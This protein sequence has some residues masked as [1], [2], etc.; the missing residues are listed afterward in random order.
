[1]AIQ[2]AAYYGTTPEE[3]AE[4][5]GGN[6]RYYLDYYLQEGL[7]EFLR[8][9]HKLNLLPETHYDGARKTLL[10]GIPAQRKEPSTEQILEGLAA[11]H[12]LAAQDA[13]VLLNCAGLAQLDAA[14]ADA[15]RARHPQTLS[16][17]LQE[18]EDEQ[19]AIEA[20]TECTQKNQN[21][22]LY[23]SLRSSSGQL[24]PIYRYEKLIAALRGK[25]SA[26]LQAFSI[27]A[28]IQLAD[29]HGMSFEDA[30]NRVVREGVVVGSSGG[31]MLSP[32]AEGSA[33]E[34]W[35]TYC[36]RLHFLGRQSLC[37]MRFSPDDSAEDRLLHLQKLRCLQDETGGFTYF[38]PLPGKDDIDAETQAK[39]YLVALLFLDNMRTFIRTGEEQRLFN[40][41]SLE[42]R[43]D[44]LFA[45]QPASQD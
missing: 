26:S 15:Y 4:F 19:A 27:P 39:E 38:S 22:R 9:A 35:L 41:L 40:G 37:T 23:L 28:L 5:V 24:S 1:M 11:G 43:P 3:A 2:H 16:V 17:V 30:V 13:L 44:I 6:R 45:L 42:T 10:A 31:E 32:A 20:V 25:C 18:L 7:A 33:A 34:K 29:R 36:R 8:R 14:A 12:R 21:T